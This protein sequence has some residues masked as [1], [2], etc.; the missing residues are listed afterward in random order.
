VRR[1]RLTVCAALA[2]AAATASILPFAQAAS[3]NSNSVAIN[4]V[5]LTTSAPAT[6]TVTTQSDTPIT[7]L[8]VTFQGSSGS[9][10]VVDLTG[11]ESGSGTFSAQMTSTDA[12]SPNYLPPGN[13]TA[14][15]EATDSGGDP[16]ASTTVPLSFLIQPTVL[17]NPSTV[18]YDQ[19]TATFTGQVTG[20]QPGETQPVTLSGEHITVSGQGGPFTGTT[21]PN[22]D[23]SIPA[24]AAVPNH[25]YTAAVAPTSQAA[26]ATSKQVT[27]TETADQVSLT[28]K[29]AKGTI[30]YG[31][32]DSISGTVSYQPN[33]M[34]ALVVPLPS[35]KVT[36]TAPGQKTIIATTKTNGTFTATLPAQHATTSWTVSAGGTALLTLD[37]AALKLNVQLPTEFKK[38]SLSLGA[39]RTLSV[40]AC[41]NVTSPGGSKDVI[42]EPVTLQYA[43][44]AKGPWKKLAT[45]QPHE[46]TTGYCAGGTPIWLGSAR[47]PVANGYY[48]LSFS[49]SSGFQAAITAAAHRWRYLTKITSFKVTPHQ[50][51]DQ[52]AVTVSGRLWHDTG[53]WHPYA[54]HPV[55]VMFLYKGDWFVYDA[56]PKT[57]SGG[58]FKGR[59]TVYETAPFIAQYEGDKT[60]FGVASSRVS[61]TVTSS[62]TLPS[63][64]TLPGIHRLRPGQ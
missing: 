46:N 19:P 48:R 8:T 60:D 35:A 21:G 12:T 49:G 1:C 32:T 15:V 44:G 17:L 9:P 4:S 11:D 54:D 56:E 50:V 34:P 5:T 30:K 16:P 61:I 27:L 63:P 18:D 36:I 53:S 57:N 26:A 42:I 55:L 62:G 43:K 23:F 6:L 33:A 7:S 13:Y 40:K 3:A 14:T 51:A 59:F 52:G 45:I 20:L 2:L 39:F 25:V 28:A 10:F 29:L 38:V 41:L 24:A 22:G 37:T 31:Q 64:G 47:V 58:Y